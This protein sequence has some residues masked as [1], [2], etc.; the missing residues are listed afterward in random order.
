MKLLGWLKKKKKLPP[1]YTTAPDIK[2]EELHIVEL[3]SESYIDLADLGCFNEEIM[4]NLLAANLGQ[5]ILPYISYQSEE[6]GTRKIVRARLEVLDR[7][8]VV[9]GNTQG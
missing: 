5:Q 4:K 9:D 3:Q 2:C 1:Y 6:R 7:T 8:E